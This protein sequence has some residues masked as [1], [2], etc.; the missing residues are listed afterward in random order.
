MDK[1]ESCGTKEL[2][3]FLNQ[4]I[5]ALRVE[6]L[7]LMNEVERLTMSVDVKDAQVVCNANYNNYMN[8][9]YNLKEYGK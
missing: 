8:Y 7:K 9:N 5:E 3:N 2:V 1:I 4:R 6:N